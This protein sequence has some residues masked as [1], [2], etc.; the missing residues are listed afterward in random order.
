MAL[1]MVGLS[2]A[3]ASSSDSLLPGGFGTAASPVVHVGNVLRFRGHA[4]PQTVE[5]GV[6]E[7]PLRQALPGELVLGDW[8]GDGVATPGSFQEGRWRLHN[9]LDAADEPDIFWFGQAGDEPFVGD[10][11][12]DGYATAAIRRGER[13]LL[14]GADH[15]TAY[16]F[17]FGRA[18]DTPV[19][20]DFNG[21]GRDTVGVRRAGTFYL[22]NRTRGGSADVTTTFGRST[23]VPFLGDWNGD[24]RT[25]V[26]VRR[27]NRFLLTDDN[28][29]VASEFTFGR[30][31]ENALV[32][33]GARSAQGC[34]TAA[35]SRSSVGGTVHEEV[36]PP[37]FGTPQ[38]GDA[39]LDEVLHTANR[40]L[41]NTNWEQE[42]EGRP[43][44]DGYLDIIGSRPRGLEHS[45]RPPAMEA[46]SIAI[47]LR[48][49]Y[50][51]ERTG[52]SREFATGQV[53]SIVRSLACQHK[54]T[55]I[56]GWGD[57]W[58][59]AYWA[60]FAGL[61]AWLVWGDLNLDDRAHVA[62][63]VVHEADRFVDRPAPFW[64]D[65]SGNGPENT[66]AEEIAWD[67]SL[68]SLATAMMP[69]HAHRDAWQATE[70]RHA[71]AAA[72]MP[73]D[74]TN[75]AALHGQPVREWVAGYNVMGDGL[76]YN[77]DRI[78]PDYSAALHA[79]WTGGLFHTLAEQSTPRALF[80]NADRIY[81]AL[82]TVDFPTGTVYVPDSSEI[83]YPSPSSWSGI[84]RAQF[85]NFDAMAHTFG[86][87]ELSPVPAQTWQS[88]HAQGQR[89]LQDRHDDGRTYSGIVEHRYPGREQLTAH[90]LAFARLS[91]HVESLGTF[92]LE[93]R[94]RAPERPD[95]SSDAPA[96]PSPTPTDI[97]DWERTAV[98]LA[99]DVH[100]DGR[101]ALGW[102]R[103]GNWALTRHDH[104][105]YRFIYGREDDVPL[106]GD[107]NGDGRATVGIRRGGTYY[108]SNRVSGGPAD[109]SF[110]YGRAGDEALV[111]DWNGDGRDT[112]GLR[113]GATFYL[114]NGP[115]GGA[116]DLTI[117]YGR[118]TDQALV[119]DWNGDGASTLGI[120]RGRDHHLVNGLR[121]G[122]ADYAFR[123]GLADD[124]PLVGDFDGD[125]RD[126]VSIVRSTTFHINDHPEGGAPSRAVTP[127]ATG[128]T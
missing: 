95:P 120:R 12:G 71:V 111:G 18:S 75:D 28:R 98:P 62:R 45:V 113:R 17:A 99:A 38:A 67:T 97:T 27:G 85:V 66:Y 6:T 103:A 32:W 36:R 16:D 64:R 5:Q 55:T 125:G 118:D 86:L 14:S 128:L 40:Y 102:W 123:Y 56:G 115:R 48:T 72:A 83:R 9:E 34:P 21:D 1:A 31:S 46:A 15:G 90:L 43:H 80:H 25:S 117:T 81:G 84:Q 44:R 93:D 33:A 100:G 88:L 57:H 20:G 11:N 73:H 52:R 13:F 74:L 41:L 30:S 19:V 10:W 59:S 121:G 24:G 92:E 96:P 94:D 26:G 37:V 50:D 104:H 127:P 89:Q 2:P 70:V 49:G 3:D 65:A 79:L 29:T 60:Q 77:H 124:R 22:S 4:T 63:M 35:F 114:S 82:S 23:D 91:E 126:T 106:L 116:A 122:P 61:A 101:S 119:G 112:I 109:Y 105:R 8:D 39:D 7:V 108:L 58:Q 87:D 47:S 53:V 42:W 68:V 69:D 107:W 54:A 76:V 51:A 78:S 110:R